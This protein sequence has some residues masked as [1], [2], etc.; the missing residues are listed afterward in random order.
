[1]RGRS[2]ENEHGGSEENERGGSPYPP[3]DGLAN[4]GEHAFLHGGDAALPRFFRV[5]PDNPH[6]RHILADRRAA[7]L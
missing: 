2:E 7:T 3:R 6:A 4:A 1:L 5:V